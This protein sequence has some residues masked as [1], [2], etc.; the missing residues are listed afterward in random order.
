MSLH[1]TVA[2]VIRRHARYLVVEEARGGPETVFNQPAGH[3]EPGE[4]P[5]AAIVREVQ[6]ETAWDIQLTG[7]LGLYV[8]HTASGLTFHS[9]AFTAEPIHFRDTPLDNDITATHW[10]TREELHAL[11]A[12]GRLRSPLVLTRIEDAHAGTIHPLNVI[13]ESPCF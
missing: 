5:L 8:F 3:V 6:E 11:N 13:H 4:G 2:C 10:L 1:T 12:Q 9:H 7:Y